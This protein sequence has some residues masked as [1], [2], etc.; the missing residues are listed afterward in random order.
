MSL[1]CWEGWDAM[2]LFPPLGSFSEYQEVR[3][4][5]KAQDCDTF[6]K[7]VDPVDMQTNLA[8]LQNGAFAVSVASSVQQAWRPGA[9]WTA[10]CALISLSEAQLCEG[11]SELLHGWEVLISSHAVFQ[12]VSWKGPGLLVQP[13]LKH[14]PGFSMILGQDMG[15]GWWGGDK[16]WKIQARSGNYK[17]ISYSSWRYQT[18]LEK[19]L[20][21][22]FL[23]IYEQ[24]YVLVCLS[25]CPWWEY[26]T[27][28]G[29]SIFPRS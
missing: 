5:D 12:D 4:Q 13:I 17:S 20:G 7:Q 8:L 16:W 1:S 11:D 10:M 24:V 27:S 23:L 26:S 28:P 3:N 19:V 9:G 18:I 22:F 2:P 14:S 6:R 15:E 25:V 29:G 21:I